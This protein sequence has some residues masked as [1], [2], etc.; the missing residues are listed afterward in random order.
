MGN[1]LQDM[2]GLLSRKKVVKEVEATDFILL[3]R[4]PNPDDSMF[5][6]PKMN[7]QLI[8]VKDLKLHFDEGN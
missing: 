1:I 7:N 5:V 2:M 6:N 4:T 3:G 8:T